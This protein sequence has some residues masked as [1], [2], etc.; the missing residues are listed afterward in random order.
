[1]NVC[2]GR[3]ESTRRNRS[4][5]LKTAVFA[6]FT[7]SASS[8]RAL[9][10]EFTLRD[11]TQ[12]KA[13]LDASGLAFYFLDRVTALGIEECIPGSILEELHKNLEGNRTRVSWF[14][15]EAAALGQSLRELGIEFAFL[16]GL[17][18]PPESV[19]RSEFRD[20]TDIDILVREQYAQAV[21][22]TLEQLGYR[23]NAISG[24]TW[25]FKG[26][27]FG[28]FTLKKTYEAPTERAVEVHLLRDGDAAHV[29]DQLTRLEVQ[30]HQGKPME[31]LCAVDIFVQ[32]GKHIFKHLCGEFTRASWV[33]EFWR[34]ACARKEDIEFWREVEH[35]AA[36]EAGADIA[37]GAATLLA[38]LVFGSFAPKELSRWSMDRLPSA[39]CLWIQLYGERALVSD[40]P[41]SKLYLLLRNELPSSSQN[42]RVERR[43][44]LFPLH[45]PRRITAPQENET[46]TE[47]LHRYKVEAQFSIYRLQFHVTEGLRL[48][49]E[50]PRWERL[51]V[52]RDKNKTREMN[53]TG[54]LQSFGTDLGLGPETIKAWSS[55]KLQQE[56]KPSW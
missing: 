45:L 10:R 3:I 2:S 17:T 4:L 14:R 35:A 21:R 30:D 46:V 22:G 53:Q 6:S 42:D 55:S 43:R 23:L 34:N 5:R 29:S 44:L 47:R 24:S 15:D 48:A 32:Q 20:Q 27:R 33:L 11:W 39:I 38:S 13:W 26:G 16:K 1:M 28:K 41:G 49:L 7:D 51:R 9:L 52:H 12:A 31:A 54:E 40:P 50:A 25:E 8:A 56:D 36:R 19:I 37:I 18:L